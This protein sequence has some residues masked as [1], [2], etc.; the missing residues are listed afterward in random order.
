MELT[1]LA[2]ITGEAWLT[3]T[4]ER[5]CVIDTDATTGTRHAATLVDVCQHR[6]TTRMFNDAIYSCLRKQ[7]GAGT[8][9]KLDLLYYCK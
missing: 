1:I 3:L 8:R 4:V 5:V 7:R 6:V 2:V 9:G